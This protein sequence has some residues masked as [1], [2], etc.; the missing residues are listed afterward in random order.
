MKKFLLFLVSAIVMLTSTTSCS[1]IDD[2]FSV[3]EISR[4]YVVFLHS[5]TCGYSRSARVYIEMTYPNAKITY[6]DIDKE[7]NADFLRTALKEYHLGTAIQTPVICFGAQHIEGWDSDKQ[8]QLDL[9]IQPYL[10]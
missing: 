9:L 4:D 7:E 2:D 5:Q 10:Q 3:I 1:V 8:R 6:I